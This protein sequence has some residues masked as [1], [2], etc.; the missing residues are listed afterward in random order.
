MA[1]L[2][3][4]SRATIYNVIAQRDFPK[5]TVISKRNVWFKSDVLKWLESRKNG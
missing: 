5:P 2:I 1:E 3:G 4:V